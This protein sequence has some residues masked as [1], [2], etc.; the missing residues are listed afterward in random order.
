MLSPS[1]SCIIHTFFCVCAYYQA[2]F[3]MDVGLDNFCNKAVM[4][5]CTTVGA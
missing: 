1:F 2:V 4:P 5:Y 3:K